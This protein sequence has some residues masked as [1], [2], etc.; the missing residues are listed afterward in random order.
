MIQ[1]YL[2]YIIFLT[3]LSFS[4]QQS[5]EKVEFAV[6]Q[7]D[8]TSFNCK[9]YD[10]E[11]N[12]DGTFNGSPSI[13]DDFQIGLE[14]SDGKKIRSKC[15]PLNV[16]LSSKITCKIDNCLYP[17]DKVNIIFPTR[18]PQTDL[19][20]FKNWENTIGKQPGTSNIISS[21]ECLTK[22]SSNKFIISSIKEDFCIQGSNYFTIKGDWEN[23]DKEVRNSDISGFDLLLDNENK[24]EA[25]CLYFPNENPIQFQC[26]F[27]GYGKIKLKE[28]L[29]KG[30]LKAF[31]INAF[32]S[33]KSVKSC[34]DDDGDDDDDII[35]RI[36]SGSFNFL[37]K[38]L[39][40]IGFLLF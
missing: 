7:L 15:R 37:N 33:G 10:Y 39:I 35:I 2:Q 26:H 32:D 23:K 31:T 38:I 24:D 21:V 34:T 4:F 6:E 28:Q 13:F 29:F 19:V 5:K 17:L 8:K 11:F 16:L 20:S 40:L 3:L 25:H 9:N 14:T 36:S 30:S 18:A 27:E 1:S 12:I 22:E